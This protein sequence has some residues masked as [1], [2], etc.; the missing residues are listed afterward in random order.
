V[1]APRDLRGPSERARARGP[2]VSRHYDIRYAIGPPRSGGPA[3]AGG[4]VRPSRPRLPDHLLTTALADLWMPAVFVSL[5]ER[6]A[7]ST[8]EL[9][10][11]YLAPVNGLAK[12]GWY[13][14]LFSAP[15]AGHGYFREEGGVWGEDGRLLARSSQ[16]A[17]FRAGS[18][19]A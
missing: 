17:V 13:L 11:N 10:V 8:V 5:R 18:R 15:A 7:T 2:G 1:P 6:M 4:W 9:T 19:R 12:D 14:T 16:L 3:Y